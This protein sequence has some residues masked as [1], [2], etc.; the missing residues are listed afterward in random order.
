MPGTHV[1]GGGRPAAAAPAALKTARSLAPPPAPC[2]QAHRARDF[3]CQEEHLR[4]L[5]FAFLGQQQSFR[6]GGVRLLWSSRRRRLLLTAAAASAPR[7]SF[8]SCWPS[9][10]SNPHCPP[11]TT[12][13]ADSLGSSK[14]PAV[15]AR[16]FAL[17]ALQTAANDT[18]AQVIMRGPVGGGAGM[19]CLWSC[20][21]Y[22]QIHC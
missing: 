21:S 17:L 19:A 11:L 12:N 1:Q 18:D 3:L 15:V 14:K 7:R 10:H 4:C 9:L 22:Y 2:L 8:L 13:H 5:L 20:V 6:Q 16:L